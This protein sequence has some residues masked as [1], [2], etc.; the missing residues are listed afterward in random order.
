MKLLVK[1]RKEAFKQEPRPNEE[2]K[3]KV[4]DLSTFLNHYKAIYF[5]VLE[6]LQMDKA[7][8]DQEKY[9]AIQFI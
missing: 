8:R 3:W 9:I 4:E 2:D 5:K 7:A 1:E 6:D